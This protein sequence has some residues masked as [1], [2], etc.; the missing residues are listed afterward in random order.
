MDCF[1]PIKHQG[2]SILFNDCHMHPTMVVYTSLTIFPPAYEAVS[3]LF[4]RPLY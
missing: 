1:D 4:V 3:L 2:I